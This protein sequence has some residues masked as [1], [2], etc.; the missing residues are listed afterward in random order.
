[1]IDWIFDEWPGHRVVSSERSEA[2]SESQRCSR[3]RGASRQR[4]DELVEIRVRMTAIDVALADN[5]RI[6]LAALECESLEAEHELQRQQIL[7]DTGVRHHCGLS[8]VPF[9][10]GVADNPGRLP[11][12]DSYGVSA[13]RNPAPGIRMRRVVL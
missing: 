2:F 6:E 11:T 3:P 7:P 13:D 8:E 12:D 10:E 5:S 4:R 1:M 9:R